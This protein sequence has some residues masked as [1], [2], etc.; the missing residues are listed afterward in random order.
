MVW[1]YLA[2]GQYNRIYIDL[3]NHL[4]LKR[5]IIPEH[6]YDAPKRSV[7]IW[8]IIN[9]HL[10]RPAQLH[11]DGWICPYIEGR[12]ATD[13]EIHQYLIQIYNRYNRIV[14]DACSPK[15]M[16]FSI[17]EQ[18]VV[19]V[20]V[21]MAVLMDVHG[22]IKKNSSLVSL[23]IWKELRF[24]Y[25]VYFFLT[26]KHRR[27]SSLFHIDRIFFYFQYDLKLHWLHLSL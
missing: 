16:I 19:C 7:R 5:A 21:G 14:I 22:P 4:V 20:D 18:K 17:A 13:F 27:A 24:N 9:G 8:N 11:P 25:F 15:N 23:S 1:Q 26:Q 6:P 2:Q 3:E 10:T 12:Q